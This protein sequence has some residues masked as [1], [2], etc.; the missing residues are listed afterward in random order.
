MLVLWLISVFA[1]DVSIV[2]V[3]WGLGFVAV[4]W[5]AFVSAQPSGTRAYLLLGLVTA[6]GIRLAFYLSWRG[7]G[8]GEDYRYRAMRETAGDS[9]WWR[10]IYLIFG[11]QAV[12]ILIISLPLVV[13]IALYGDRGLSVLGYFGVLIC[14]VGFV[15]EWGG[16]W[17]L[18]QFR[19]QP[20][21]R[22]KVMTSGLWAYTRHPNYFGDFMVWWGLTAIASPEAHRSWVIVGPLIMTVM[23]LKVSGVGLL[24]KTMASRP[25]YAEYMRRTN[26]FFPGPRR[27]QE[28]AS[29]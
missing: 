27:S 13:G 4:A 7:W 6:W 24:E 3:F 5:T 29:I 28:D 21:N 26:A 9:F 25:G 14:L 16:D 19:R 12:L 11:F 17:Q 15:F 10:S 20:Q 1:K 2:D 22:G 8:Q 18:S 23:L